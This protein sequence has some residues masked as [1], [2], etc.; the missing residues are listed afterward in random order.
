METSIISGVQIDLGL[1][2][3][4][5]T[6]FTLLQH[7]IFGMIYSK[8]VDGLGMHDKK[9]WAWIPILNLMLFYK[10]VQSDKASQ[11]TKSLLVIASVFLAIL[12]ATPWLLILTEQAAPGLVLGAVNMIILQVFFYGYGI[13]RINKIFD[14]RLNGAR[15]Q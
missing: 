15:V 6:I 9:M 8:L 5:F 3:M 12:P 11:N 1:I 2:I 7:S 13:W 10:I 14:H 4:I